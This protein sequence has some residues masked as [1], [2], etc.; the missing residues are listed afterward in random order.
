MSLLS[1]LHILHVILL[2]LLLTLKRQM[3]ASN[4]CYRSIYPRVE[5]HRFIVFMVN[6]KQISDLGLV[7]LWLILSMSLIAGFDISYFNRF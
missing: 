7:F 3:F 6:F 4:R 2:S 1:V 5:R